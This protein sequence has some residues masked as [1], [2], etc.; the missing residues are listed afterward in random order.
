MLGLSYRSVANVLCS[1]GCAS[2]KSA[3]ERDLA[4]AGQQ[5]RI[6]HHQAPK[7]HVRV[8]GIDG[9]GAKMAGQK[10]GMLFFVDID[11]QRLICVE[12]VDETDS[13]LVRWHIRRVLEFTGAKEVRT[14]D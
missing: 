2:S 1:L 8:L 13:H 14:D 6:L 9:T 4:D 5:A 3:I 7:M 11:S 10:G 12:P